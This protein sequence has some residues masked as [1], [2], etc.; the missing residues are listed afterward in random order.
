MMVPAKSI[1]GRMAAFLLACGFTTG[2]FERP[3]P[4]PDADA[5]AGCFVNPTSER[6]VTLR[7]LPPDTARVNVA[8]S[9]RRIVA[10]AAVNAAA[11]DSAILR[12]EWLD[13]TA[14]VRYCMGFQTPRRLA[15]D[16]AYP[17]II[18][19]HGG[20][21]TERNDKGDSAVRMLTDLADTFDLFLA[22][23][24]ANRYTPWWS[25]AGLSRI[26]QTLR[27]MTLHYPINPSKVFLAGVSDG[28]TGC[29]A[30]ANTIPGPFAGFIAVSGFGG[31]LPMVGMPLS[32]GN[33]AQRP[34]YNVNAGHDRIYPIEQVK[35]F[36]E[37]LREQG[38]P[39]TATYYP[40]EQHGFDYR[41][42]EMGALAWLIR[43][44]S[45]PVRAAIDWTFIDG[46]PNLPDNLL[47]W[48][49]DSVDAAIRGRW[50]GDTLVINERGL[51]TITAIFPQFSSSKLV[52]SLRSGRVR[53]IA[54]APLAWPD[55]LHLMLHRCMP[56]LTGGVIYKIKI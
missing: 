6:F 5:I 46:F 42:K 13:D 16:T 45:R 2:C 18:Y 52:C 56:G 3:A 44:W 24:S 49:I 37:A 36:V 30:A 19:L 50:Q 48:T 27:Y 25:P 20:S 29:Y 4:A 32:P 47:S 28:A 41:A 31:M 10:A 38:V 8:L 43:S 17:L 39:I 23:P 26:L 53:F 14:G 34:I 33:M 1:S 21:G 9:A 7:T 54:A 51:Q 40:D 55:N 11:G 35:K 22:S 15:V 12:Q